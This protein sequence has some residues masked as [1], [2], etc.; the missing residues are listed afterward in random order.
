VADQHLGDEPQ[1]RALRPAY[2]AELDQ[3]H[4]QVELMAMRVDQNLERTRT[5]LQSGDLAVA[6]EAIRADDDI[7]AMS[8][9]LTERCY[10]LLAREQPVAGDLRFIVSVLRVLGEFER[11][12]DLALR[13]VKL[14]PDFD[15]IR[16]NP[17]TYEI[18]LS[19]A[20]A[21]IER[22]REAMR[23]WSGPSAEVARR[24]LATPSMA[25]H[26]EER[27]TTELM[28][29]QGSDAAAVAIR[30]LV[31]GKSLERIADHAGIIGAR[32]LFLVTGDAGHLAH[33]VR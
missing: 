21:A 26:L 12:G 33:E 24:L 7:D 5:V 15:L 11:I 19:M 17:S 18:L 32:L 1:G 14:A 2:A 6:D 4:L 29:L 20:D 10:D 25:G 22:Y 27:L 9:S 16:S 30:T 28:A 3:L 23:A 8:V 31:A 13:V